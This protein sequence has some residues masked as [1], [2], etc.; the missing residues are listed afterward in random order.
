LGSLSSHCP[1]CG[2]L[3]QQEFPQQAGYLPPMQKREEVTEEE[4]KRIEESKVPLTPR[5][6]KILLQKD[7]VIVCKR[8]HSFKSGKE[9][10]VSPKSNRIQFKEVKQRS[11]GLIILVLDL[12]D[13]PGSMIHDLSDYVGTKDLIVVL[14]KADLMPSQLDMT[15]VISYVGSQT[16]AQHALDIF[17][18][19]AKDG[20]GLST[21]TSHL[22][23]RFSQNEDCYL[24]GAASS[25]KSTILNQLKQLIGDKRL[26][27]TSRQGGTTVGMIKMSSLD[28]L[29]AIRRLEAEETLVDEAIVD[30]MEDS[31]AQ[32]HFLYD[33][34]GIIQSHQLLHLFGEK[35]LSYFTPST[36][37]IITKLNR[38]KSEV[39]YLGGFCRVEL[40]LAHEPIQFRVYSSAKLKIHKG[41]AAKVPYLDSQIGANDQILYPPINAKR[42]IPFPTLKLAAKVKH[43]S[44]RPAVFY[45]SGAGWFTVDRSCHFEVYTPDG[46]GFF[47]IYGHNFLNS[48]QHN[49]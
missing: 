24:V 36:K 20:S 11:G 1:G 37:M 41:R 35:E 22:S 8:C 16:F 49:L 21:L 30:K 34:I 25:G 2:A 40:K 17:P 31:S 13:L 4:I 29:P 46:L 5:E 33:T 45:I 38:R 47:P 27:T 23:N 14:N 44:N 9:R 7:K 39:F 10:S 32:E 6:I 26:A 3:F 15:K 42:K 48:N 28:L 18:M 12:V 19:S 43:S